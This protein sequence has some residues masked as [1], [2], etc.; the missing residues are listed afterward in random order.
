MLF[1][2][3]INNN[4]I[5]PSCK[6]LPAEM[7]AAAKQPVRSWLCKS[8]QLQLDQ[9]SWSSQQS[10]I[11]R[12]RTEWINVKHNCHWKSHGSIIRWWEKKYVWVDQIFTNC[13][14]LICLNNFKNSWS[15][16]WNPKCKRLGIW[17]IYWVE[18]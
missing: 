6:I 8:Q 4:C 10:W 13:Q 12:K 16:Q 17:G 2:D 7:H 1:L 11:Q 3:Y 9:P 5:H 15:F 14:D 18:P